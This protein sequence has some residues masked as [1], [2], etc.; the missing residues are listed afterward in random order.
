MPRTARESWIHRVAWVY[1]ASCTAQPWLKTTLRHCWRR[2]YKSL[3]DPVFVVA[4][5]TE[6]I[7][8]DVPFPDLG[9]LAELHE[10]F[11]PYLA[12]EED[13]ETAT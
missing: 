6:P 4:A 9:P 13:Q 12:A 1:A 3:R 2:L 5:I 8:E 10:W 11:R 7:V